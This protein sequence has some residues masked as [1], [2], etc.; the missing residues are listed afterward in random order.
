MKNMTVIPAK[1][2][3]GNAA[4]KVEVKRLRVAAYCRVSTDNEEQA[5][6]YEAQIQHYEEFIK[7]NPEW[8]FV[9]VYADEGISATSTKKREQFNALIEDCKA[10]KI[11]MIFTKSIS[12][13][14][15]N[16][17]DCLKYIRLLK[18]INIPVFFEKESINTMDAK[19][20]VL[21]TIMASLA[22]QESESLSKNT[23]MGIQYRFQQG[24]VMVNARHF[25]GYDKDEEGHLVINP[26]EAEIVKRIYREYLEG[27]SC[28]KIAKGLERDGIRTSRGNPRWHD[29]TVRKILENEKYMGD[30]LLQKTY[31]ID[32]LNKKRGKNNGTLPQYYIEDDHE[33]IIPKDLFLRVQEEMARRSSERDMNGRRRGFSANHAF[34]HMVICECCGENFRRLHWNNRGKKTIVWR[35]KTRLEDKTRCTA[36]TVREE[37]LKAA[38]LEALNEMVCDSDTYLNRLRENLEAAIN[39]ANPMSAEAL[40]AKM[41]ELQREL[42]NRTERRE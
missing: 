1:P 11:D 9:G 19:G 10:G 35:C 25:L 32:F 40:S 15:R 8:E 21:I 28:K 23:K 26:E 39:S 6:S 31:T 7:T 27:A 22:Q 29:S 30:A 13:F 42:I 37:T 41:A 18:E 16:T 38:F 20:E 14:A 33:A 17:L 34:S 2:Q 36:R 5:S 4:A 3:K 24:K 12:R